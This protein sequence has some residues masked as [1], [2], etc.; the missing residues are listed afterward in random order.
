MSEFVAKVRTLSCGEVRDAAG[1]RR[2]SARKERDRG[3]RPHER[4]VAEVVE[5][6]D[7]LERMGVAL[8]AAAAHAEQRLVVV[9]A[10]KVAAE[11]SLASVKVG[12]AN[13]KLL[14]RAGGQWHVGRR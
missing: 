5:R 9:I 6:S 3:A 13:R 1:H 11:T 12:V 4:S 2:L 10:G 14:A 8:A 7:R